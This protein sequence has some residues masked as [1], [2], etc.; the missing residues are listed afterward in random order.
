M[1]DLVERVNWDE[2]L[3]YLSQGDPSIGLQ[4]VILNAVLLGWWLLMRI[5]KR[6][7]HQKSSSRFLPVVMLAG[8]VGIV[9]LGSWIA[10]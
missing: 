9:T 1:L 8:N 2:Y 4:L 3:T 10:I 5:K 6:K 7:L